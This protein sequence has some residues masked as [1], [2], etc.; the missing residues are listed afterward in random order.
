MKTSEDEDSLDHG[1]MRN[2]KFI[3]SN[4]KNNKFHISSKN[5]FGKRAGGDKLLE[6]S[7]R[8]LRKTSHN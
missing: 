8:A 4:T 5:S 2:D 1:D 3:A 6:V 7:E